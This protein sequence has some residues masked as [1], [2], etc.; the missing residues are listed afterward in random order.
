M[1]VRK[2]I[3]MGA[4]AGLLI[5]SGCAKKEVPAPE[6]APV[7]EEVAEVAPAPTVAKAMLQARADTTASG[8]V[9]FTQ[10]DAGVDIEA[11]VEGLSAGLHGFHVHATGDCSSEDFKSTGGHFNPTEVPHG[12]PTDSARH[13]GDLGNVEA[14][15]DGSA[16]LM[17]SSTMLTLDDGP[18]SVLGK[19]VIVHEKADD[20]E[21]QPTG[22]AG[23][24]VACGVVALEDD[25][26]AK[27]E[28]VGEGYGDEEYVAPTEE[29]EGQ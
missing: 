20:L 28:Y 25:G 19:G 15:E 16:H 6:P 26:Y 10:T 1:S 12:A 18:N 23:S 17:A 2:S 13:A 24:R 9:T 7:Q 29:A 5:V 14:G 21:S 8:W 22:V 11:H 27:D 4:A 3:W